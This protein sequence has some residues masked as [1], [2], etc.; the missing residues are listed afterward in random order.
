MLSNCA[1]WSMATGGPLG[2][3]AQQR[4]AALEYEPC[5]VLCSNEMGRVEQFPLRSLQSSRNYAF[6]LLSAYVSPL[7]HYERAGYV[8]I[9]DG[10]TAHVLQVVPRVSYLINDVWSV[11][12]SVPFEYNRADGLV[13]P[14]LHQTETTHSA[15][16]PDGATL[17]LEYR[18][19]RLFFERIVARVG[20]GYRVSMPSGTA[21]V[22]AELE[23]QPDKALEALGFGSDDLFL[24]GS[25]RR[26]APAGG[27]WD[28]G[29]GGELRLHTLPR[30][31]KLFATTYAY[32]VDARRPVGSRWELYGRASGFSTRIRALEVTQANRAILMVG[33]HFR[34]SD[35]MIL[36]L[37][38]KGELPIAAV[39]T[40]SLQTV[41]LNWG[42]TVFR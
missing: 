21:D 40:N 35:T 18:I 22:S 19:P 2:A 29:L 6:S 16:E 24:T 23:Q 26:L 13:L 27:L 30:F 15:L 17:S 4:P 37:G 38:L 20:G 42:V 7:G 1:F 32:Y 11:Q 3:A 25:V 41:G 28:V 5:H 10:A 12:L 34:Y 36:F 33:S 39:N 14:T 9:S 31:R 8:R